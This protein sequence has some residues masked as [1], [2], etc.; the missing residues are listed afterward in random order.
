VDGCQELSL[1]RS[2]HRPA[3]RLRRELWFEQLRTFFQQNGLPGAGFGDQG[4]STL[5]IVCFREAEYETYRLRAAADSYYVQDGN[6]EY[7]VLAAP[8]FMTFGVAAHEYTHHVLQANGLK[9]PAFLNEGLGEFYSTLRVTRSGYEVGGDLLAR[10]Q[11][12]QTS[13]WLPLAELVN[14]QPETRAGAAIFYAESWALVDMLLMSPAYTSH[15]RELVSEFSGGTSAVEAFRKV[16]GK[17]LAQVAKGLD[18][19]SGQPRSTRIVLSRPVELAKPDTSEL[20]ARQS[21]VL[22]VP[23]CINQST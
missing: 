2:I 4:G 3:A 10:T 22:L 18:Y 19:W 5:R 9:L 12:L 23:T 21:N 14:A 15:F 20:S 6:R 1:L 8:R 11:T 17:S 13:R 7:I 16:Y